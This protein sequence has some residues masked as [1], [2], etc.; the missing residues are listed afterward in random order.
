[1]SS[2]RSCVKNRVCLLCYERDPAHCHRSR[3]AELIRE[4][5]GV[6]VKDLIPTLE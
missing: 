2:P 5:T 1:M 6:E 4:R 3:I